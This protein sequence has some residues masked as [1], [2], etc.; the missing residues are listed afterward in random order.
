MDAA[1]T[2]LANRHGEEAAVT[3]RLPS[4][5][6]GAVLLAQSL[7]GF[8]LGGQ[9]LSLAKDALPLLDTGWIPNAGQWEGQAAFS[10]PSF[11]GPTWTFGMGTFVM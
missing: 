4:R 6:W 8:F 9:V 1:V 10:A 11:T 2:R 5:W 7:Q 3:R